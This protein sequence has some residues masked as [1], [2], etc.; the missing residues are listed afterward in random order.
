MLRALAERHRGII[1]RTAIEAAGVHY[2]AI[3]RRVANG[4][5][6]ERH[7]G[8]FTFGHGPLPPESR[9]LAALVWGGGCAH[10]SHLSAA[11]VFGWV[12]F[13]DDVHLTTT[14]RHGS[15]PGIVVHS[16]QR[17]PA[18]H[19][20]HWEDLRVTVRSRTLVDLADVLDYDELRRVADQPHRLPIAHLELTLTELQGRH[21]AGRVARLIRSEEAHTKSDLERRFLAYCRVHR[22]PRPS[23]LNHQIGPHKADC[24]YEDELLVLE[25]DGR[26]HHERR[27]QTKLDHQR[28]MDYQL[29]GYR[30]GRFDWEDLDPA[31]PVAASRIRALLTLGVRG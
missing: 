15:R 5:L 22:L 3:T 14:D 9:M 19:R 12:P 2:R 11:A 27:A 18:S 28:D 25:L 17:L 29:A 16:T 4:R 7:P 1:D 8:V 20:Q 10:L 24:V 21:G 13:P 23:K 31:S 26:A 30:F 6:C